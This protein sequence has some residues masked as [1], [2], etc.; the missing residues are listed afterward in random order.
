MS[1][2]PRRHVHIKGVLSGGGLDDGNLMFADVQTVDDTVTRISVPFERMNETVLAM[3]AFTGVVNQQRHQ[4]G[5]T[6]DKGIM[7]HGLNTVASPDKS[8]IEIRIEVKLGDETVYLPPVVVP[9]VSSRQLAA[10]LLK[11]A[12]EVDPPKRA[13]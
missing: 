2:R 8:S 5:R 7:C 6:P 12:D 4:H 1:L 10:S 3:L 9:A 11:W 13:D